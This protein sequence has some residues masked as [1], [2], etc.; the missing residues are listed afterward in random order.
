MRN[1]KILI[2]FVLA[3]V[4]FSC[5]VDEN[6][7]LDDVAN[8]PAPANI[9]ALFTITQDNTGLVTI[10]PR[11]EGVGSYEVYY[12]DTTEEPGIVLAGKTITHTYAEGNYS[13]KI[14]GKSVNGKTAEYIHDL[15]VSFVAP[16]N[17]QVT[18]AP[19]VGDPLS[20]NVSAKADLEAFFE[21]WFGESEDEEPVQFNEGET[22]MH[23]Y[24]AI[25]TY[26]VKVVA[27]SG[28]AATTEYTQNVTITNPLLLPINFENPTLNY[29]FT[30]FNGATAG[31]IDNP[32]ASGINTSDKVAFMTPAAGGTWTGGLLTLDSPLDL[33]SLTNIKVKVWS[34]QTGVIVK[35]KVENLND[36]NQSYE[37]DRVTS[38]SNQWEELVYDFS[39]ANMDQEYSK[40]VFFF[41]AGSP[42]TGDTYY[43]DDISQ[44]AGENAIVLPLTFETSSLDYTFNTFEGSAV[45]KI[46]NP[47]PE[48]INTSGNVVEFIKTN[49]AGIYAGV[50]MPLDDVIDFTVQKKIKIKVW[51]PA[52]GKTILL[53]FESIPNVDGTSIEKSALT[54]VANAWEELTFD[55]SDISTTINYQ[56]VVLFCDFNVSGTGTTYYFDDITQAD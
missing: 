28:G 41:N 35:L 21:V 15:A 54:T 52:V 4:M 13:V 3:T 34:P 47:H 16:E 6:D 8:G 42:G 29:E 17:L 48:G 39:G 53:K 22:I 38:V 45:Q 5:T 11:G 10:A 27:Y 30:N 9:S 31:V 23:T 19:V 40:L 44:S 36:G 1:F 50:A 51:S 24:A 37:V 56:N 46:A 26:E 49:G 7:S 55:F 33:S 32:D 12:G 25:G 20:I 2:T 43:F 14:V 18:I